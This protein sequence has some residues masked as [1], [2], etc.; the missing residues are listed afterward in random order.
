MSVHEAL[1]IINKIK[2]EVLGGVGA[3]DA[4]TGFCIDWFESMGWSA[5]EFGEADILAQAKGTSL[6][7]VQD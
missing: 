5:G 4:D 2:D 3:E 1:K 7:G 6:P